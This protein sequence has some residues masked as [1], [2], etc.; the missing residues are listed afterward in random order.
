M[1]H[2]VLHP[3]HHLFYQAGQVLQENEGIGFLW[4]RKK[5]KENARVKMTWQ[6]NLTV[7]VCVWLWLFM[8]LFRNHITVNQIPRAQMKQWE[9]W[10]SRRA[11]L[12]DC[13]RKCCFA[14]QT[15]NIWCTQAQMWHIVTLM[16]SLK[17]P[18][19]TTRW[20][21]KS[22]LWNVLHCTYN[23]VSHGIFKITQGYTGH[24]GNCRDWFYHSKFK[25]LY[26]N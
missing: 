5:S 9:R 2:N 13:R 24:K 14:L 23:N 25:V 11:A 19:F 7:V 15:K 21:L 4:V 1:V 17:N 26:Y 20:K 18:V 8:S 6:I 3:R 22:N 12:K 10:H 16:K